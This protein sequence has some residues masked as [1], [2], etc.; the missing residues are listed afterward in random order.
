MIMEF[1]VKKKFYKKKK[2]KVELSRVCLKFI[3]LWGVWY[4]H[5]KT[6]NMC[7]KTCV[8]IHMGKKV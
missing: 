8:E 7:L 3:D 5:L 4:I 2:K 6:K 1:K